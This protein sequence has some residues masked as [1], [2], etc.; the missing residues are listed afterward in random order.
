[1]GSSK[2]VAAAVVFIVATTS[3]LVATLFFDLLAHSSAEA[4]LG[5]FRAWLEGHRQAAITLVAGLAGA[6][7]IVRGY[8]GLIHRVPELDG[9]RS[10]VRTPDA[11]GSVR[12][13]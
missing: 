6:W 3:G 4:R 8:S 9:V 13:R 5:T 2:S 7:L 10:G 12:P 1:V 11:V